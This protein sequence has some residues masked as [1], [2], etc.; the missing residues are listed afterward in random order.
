[1]FTASYSLY[2][3]PWGEAECLGILAETFLTNIPVT[4]GFYV[5]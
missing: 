4:S 3:Q 5:L 2:A 1:M